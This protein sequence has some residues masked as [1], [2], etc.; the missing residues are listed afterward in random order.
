M[1]Y[2]EFFREWDD[3]SADILCH[4]SGST[5]T[6]RDILLPKNEMMRSA[7]RTI[8][9]FNLDSGSHLHSCISPDYIGGKMQGVRAKILGAEFTFETPSNHPLEHYQGGRIDLLS[10]VPSQ[11]RYIL[12]HADEMPEIGAI[13]IGGA[14]IPVNIEVDI[15]QSRFS[16]WETYGMTETAS[17]IALRD[18]K[19]IGSPFRA[20]DDVNLS[21]DLEG[22]LII[23]IRDWKKITTNDIVDMYGGNQFKVVGRYDNVINSGGIKIHPERIEQIMEALL[24]CPVLITSAPDDKWGE[25]VVMVVEDSGL[26]LDEQIEEICHKHLQKQVIPKEIRHGKI[27]RTENGKKKRKL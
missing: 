11:M 19:I 21:T 27:A 8:R 1:T 5:G 17:H 9:H 20:F 26:Y 6:P 2:E 23:N 3:M 4:T 22:R 15:I 24:N 14:P 7:M 16:V 25:R 18:V 13:L 10:I 12:D